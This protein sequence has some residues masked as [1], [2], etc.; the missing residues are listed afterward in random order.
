MA[1]R[2][3]VTTLLDQGYVIVAVELPKGASLER[4]D[5]VVLEADRA[6]DV[7]HAGEP[8]AVGLARDI[9]RERERDAVEDNLGRHRAD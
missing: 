2:D 1:V 9:E 3:E 4:T 6:V 7:A 8:V 5:A